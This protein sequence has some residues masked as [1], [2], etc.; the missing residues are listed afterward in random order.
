MDDYDNY[1]EKVNATSKEEA[2]EKVKNKYPRA[3]NL[4]A[5]TINTD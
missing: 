2:I 5:K 4:V 1:T 3:K